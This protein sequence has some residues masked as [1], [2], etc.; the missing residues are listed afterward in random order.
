MKQL[1]FLCCFTLVSL[2]GFAQQI[3]VKGIVT[4][5]A[6]KLGLIGATV[7]IKGT[8]VGTITGLDGDYTLNNVPSD[9]VLVFSSIGYETQEIPVNGRTT[10]NLVMKEATELLDEVVVIGYGAVKKSDLTS[11]ISTVKGEEITETVTGNAMDAL[12]GKVNGVQV[13]SGGGPGTTPKVLIRGVTTVNGSDPLYVVDGMPISGN[14]NFLNSNDIESMQVLKDASA[15]AI[16]GTR[17]SNGVILITTKKGRA[18]KTNINFNASVGFQTVAKPN[19]AGPAEYKE[20]FNTRYTNDGSQSMWNDTGATTN[21]GGTDWWDTVVNKTAL[22][23]NYA[24]SVSGGSDKL[25]YNF[26]L[27]YY[28]NN[29]QFDVGYWDKINIR[30]NTE[31]TFNKYVKIGVDIAPRVESWDD[32]PNVF[33]AA[34]SM[35]P[36]TPVF[37]PKDQWVDNE[38][39][40]YQRSYN[41][42]EWN[43]AGTVARSSG[44]SREMGAILNGYLQINPIEKLTLRTQFGANA[45]YR[46]TDSFTPEFYIDALEQ[47][48]LSQIGRQSQEW[49]DWNW[50]N[51]ATY[52]DTFA[53]KH[54]LNVMAGFTAERFAWFNTQANRDDIPNN[55]DIMQEV[56][57]GTLDSQEGYGETSYNTLVSFLG[58]VMYN[59]DNRYYISA[60][61]RADGSSRF[62]EGN[63]YALFPS[64]SASWRVTSENFMEDQR[65]FSDLK[66][67][68]GWGRVGNQNI[69]NNA[70]MTLLSATQYYYG[71][72]VANGY[73]VSTIGNNQL[74]WETVEDWNVGVDMSFLDY[75]LGVTFEY[76]QKKSRD[77]LYQKQNILALGYENWNSQVWMNIG[78]MQARGW[79]LGLSWRDQVGKDF[80]YD[81]GLNLSAVRNKAIKF[82]GDGPI[83]VG[84]FNSDQIIR[85]EDGGLISRFYG[86]VADG[87]FQNWEEVYAHTDEHGT[88]IQPSAQPGDIR[89]KDLDHNGVLD[90]NDKTFIGNPYP[91]LMMGL[92]LSMRYKNIDFAANFYGTFGN[93][94]FNTTRGRYSGAGGQNVWAG[95]LEK[96]WHGEGTSNDIPR[97]SANDNSPNYINVSSFYVEDGSYMRCK[98]LQIGYTLPEKWVGGSQ[99]RIS[100]SAQNP[101][102][103]TGYSG[104]D[105]ER[106]MVDG[107]TDNSGSAINT[108]IDNVAYPNPRTFLFGIDF[109]F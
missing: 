96:A 92:N 99:L 91:D 20:V 71:G 34:M 66:L 77:M 46:R 10:I 27:G 5:D 29:S 81:I 93:D 39:N 23:Q 58:R 87:L 40:N 21:P 44:H 48:T 53:E 24:L 89:F 60:S 9:A 74:K 84:G 17:A 98:L 67:R 47:S 14:I 75:R 4:S 56:N 85:N 49:L 70:T 15:A 50:T 57:A 65:I 69:N 62:P 11:S 43:P 88:L 78:S 30:L 107:T 38:Y 72:T 94:I 26:S 86:Y 52:I 32:T 45:H 6:D 13:A 41:N 63:K 3:T 42:Q 97:L 83:N 16:Y 102:T 109:K 22:V 103:I 95:T 51:T 25:V 80:S 54:N 8:T 33:S 64:V 73:Y 59:Y 105:P 104:M 37:K 90:A 1:L 18:G 2:C 76:F 106:P 61:L 100:F 68:G 36:T 108:G 82:S 101:F 55:M 7:Q 31:Y 12:Q 28:K 79:E 19:I 35:D